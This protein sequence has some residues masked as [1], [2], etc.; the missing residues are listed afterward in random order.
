MKYTHTPPIT[1]S[2]PISWNSSS[3]PNSAGTEVMFSENS[4][5]RPPKWVFSYIII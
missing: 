2:D 4:L 3:L 1:R 5:D